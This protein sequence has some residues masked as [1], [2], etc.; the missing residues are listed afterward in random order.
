[1]V[2]LIFFV[3]FFSNNCFKMSATNTTTFKMEFSCSASTCSAVHGGHFILSR[4][5]IEDGNLVWTVSAKTMFE[6]AICYLKT[7]EIRCKCL[8]VKTKCNWCRSISQLVYGASYFDYQNRYTDEIFTKFKIEF[9]KNC[10]ECDQCARD[11]IVVAQ[12]LKFFK[13]VNEKQRE[14][15]LSDYVFD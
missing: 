8:E 13:L 6:I 11:K 2:R 7:R 12:P 3:I 1:M 9:G 10:V 15:Y 4:K 14:P 5:I